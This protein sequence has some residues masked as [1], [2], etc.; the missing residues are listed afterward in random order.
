MKEIKI[1]KLASFLLFVIPISALFFILLATNHLVSYTSNEFPNGVQKEQKFNCNESNEM[2]RRITSERKKLKLTEC[3]LKKY[4]HVYKKNGLVFDVAEHPTKMNEKEFLNFKIIENDRY[5]YEFILTDEI[6]NNCIKL[7]K[8]FFLYKLF[9]KL[10]NS[11]TYWQA[12]TDFAIG[13]S[14]NPFIKGETSISNIVKRYPF[15]YIFKPLMYITSILMC[16]YWINYYTFFKKNNFHGNNK[17]LVFG[18]MSSVLLFL[19]VFFLG[20]NYE[21]PYF[22]KIR[23]LIIASFIFSEILAEFFLASKIYKLRFDLFNQMRKKIIFTKMIFIYTLIIITVVSLSYMIIF[24]P[25]H[26][27]NN[28]LE[29][30]YFCFL[31]FFYLLSSIIWKKKDKWNF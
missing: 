2:C 6:N 9:P 23:R 20:T 1:I 30:N 31:L 5:D 18:I 15:N 4:K 10:E 12:K 11:Y 17:F 26:A 22:Q 25:T 3:S 8:I 7:S 14:V 29:W 27:F 19:H 16:I 24:D 28:I 13:K 21:I